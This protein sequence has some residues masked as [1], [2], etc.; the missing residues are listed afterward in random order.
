MVSLVTSP[1]PMLCPRMKM[2]RYYRN[3][4]GNVK[5]KCTTPRTPLFLLTAHSLPP[6]SLFPLPFI[7]VLVLV[8]RVFY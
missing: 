2:I 5:I 6:G 3:I 7:L 1:Q 8:D 4:S